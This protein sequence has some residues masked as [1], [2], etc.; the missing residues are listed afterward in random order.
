VFWP[1][2]QCGFVDY[3]DDQYVTANAQ[4]QR[5]LTGSSVAWAFGADGLVAA[6]WHPVTVLSHM[7]DVDVHGLDPAGHHQTSLVFHVL[8]VVL[9]FLLLRRLTGSVW[10]PA[11][12]AALFALH[13]LNVQSVAWISE[14]KNVLSTSFWLLAT[15]AYVTYARQGGALRMVAVGVLLALGLMAKSMLVTL[16]FTLLLLDVWPLR[17]LE[18]LGW[19]RLVI[20][21]LPLFAVV[22][23]ASVVTLNVQERGDAMVAAIDLPYRLA[24]AA[25]APL[26]YVGKL[27]WP[28]RLSIFYPHPGRLMTGGQMA[29]AGVSVLAVLVATVAVWRARSRAPW[30]LFG[31]LWFLGT[32]VPVLG[33]VQVGD[34]AL[35]D[36][37]LYVPALGLFVLAAW[38]VGSWA[39]RFARPQVVCAALAVVVLSACVV[40]T[41]VELG[42][43]RDSESLFRHALEEREANYLAHNNL[44]KV[45]YDQGHREQAFQH[46]Y[47]A[48]ELE[49]GYALARANLGTLYAERGELDLAEAHLLEAV[50]LPPDTALARNALGAVSLQL[51]K[52]EQAVIHLRRALEIDPDCEPARRN[53]ALIRVVDD[54]ESPEDG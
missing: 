5:G 27:L 9:L 21:K 51:G 12:V 35:A 14:R 8:N 53:L 41:R 4:V 2:L 46:V 42:A 6:N 45:L 10:A 48:A 43:W 28:Y 33:I 25:A 1:V 50:R 54:D 30:A 16:P 19:R 40:R 31:W 29:F 11:L 22:V 17:R 18:S 13:P 38:G 39:R 44:G 49:P 15:G 26:D 3:D 7:L 47:R 20:E 37:Y 36:R 34:Q 52:A 32:L 24:N 23:V